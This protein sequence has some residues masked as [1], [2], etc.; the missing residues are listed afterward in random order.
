MKENFTY[1]LFKKNHK[2]NIYVLYIEKTKP[3]WSRV[4]MIC[5]LYECSNVP[6]YLGICMTIPVRWHH[7][8]VSGLNRSNWCRLQRYKTK[9]MA[10]RPTQN[11]NESLELVKTYNNKWAQLK[12][13]KLDIFLGTINHLKIWFTN[14][15][16]RYD[17]NQSIKC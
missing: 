9:R 5:I 11:P 15:H 14:I 1:L 8:L 10:T 16:S 17:Q 13:T 12:N 7:N 3:K 4:F 6:T 2:Q